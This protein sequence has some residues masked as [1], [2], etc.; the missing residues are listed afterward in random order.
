MND[1]EHILEISRYLAVPRA[2]VWRA[3]SEPKLLAQWWCPK[4]WTTEVRAFDFRAGGDFYTF[5]R[6]PAETGGESDNPGCF[7]EIV[8][9]QRIVMTSMLT[10]GWRPAAPWLPMTAIFEMADEGEGT[11]YTARCIH[12]DPAGARKHEE[13][14]FFEGWGTCISQLE[15]FAQGL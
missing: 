7:L 1:N 10:G 5:M 9:E 4:P 15:A 6:G 8:P 13:M 12:L 3:W 14:G 11:R 2:R